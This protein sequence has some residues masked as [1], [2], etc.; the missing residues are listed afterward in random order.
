MEIV[1]SKIQKL[2]SGGG[3]PSFVSFTP[4][5]QPANVPPPAPAEA[6]KTE[7]KSEGGVGMINKDMLK[8][9][10]ENGLESDTREFVEGLDSFVSDIADNPFDKTSTVSRYK[11]LILDMSKLKNGKEELL[12]AVKESQKNGAFQELAVT[13]DGKFFVLGEDG[14]SKK[15]K[16]EQGDRVLTNAD[17][18]QMR[19]TKT[20][21]N[22][23]L[24]T[25]IANGVGMEQI[26]KKV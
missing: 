13:T 20:A 8:F 11:K 21:Y 25:T 22:N 7:E 10:Y 23:D 12:S 19:S 17:L 6:P 15:A 1:Q 14:I 9:I 18:A 2:A 16:L 24:T 5:T 4:V 3:M 26:N